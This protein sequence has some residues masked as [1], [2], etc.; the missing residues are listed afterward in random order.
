MIFIH[1]FLFNQVKIV[2]DPNHDST[3]LYQ[4]IEVELLKKPGK[5]LGLS[6]VGRRDGNGVFISDMVRK[7]YVFFGYF[8]HFFPI[9]KVVG[10]T[11]EM[12]GQLL[13]GDQIVSVNEAD[14]SEAK[15]DQAVAILKTAAGSV[16]IKVRRYKCVASSSQ[17]SMKIMQ[18]K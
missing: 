4:D 13:R 5:G 18:K 15:Q 7:I 6:V 11:A 9:F 10:G 2:I 3:D 8:T 16:K 17:C 12:N 14:L 1:T